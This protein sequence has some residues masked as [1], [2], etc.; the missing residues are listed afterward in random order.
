MKKIALLFVAV[1]AVMALGGAHATYAQGATMTVNLSE[2]N[3]S[4]QSGTATL[5]DMGDSTKVVVNISN[6]TAEPQPAHIHMGSCANLNPKPLYPLK[7]LVNGTSE[8]TVSTKLS[9]IANGG[10][11]INIHKSGAEV[12]VY[13]SCGDIAKMMTSSD[14]SAGN[15][16]GEYGTS[17]GTSAGNSGGEYGPPGMPSTGNGDM[18]I[19]AALAGI[20]GLSLTGVGL[21]LA[22]RKA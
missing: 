7:S 21:K 12:S 17:G 22:R 16:G 19:I 4:G 13:V 3:G 18:P 8:T 20:L 14:T 2:Q 6:G 5:T 10:M 15:S 1:L 9:D 11:A